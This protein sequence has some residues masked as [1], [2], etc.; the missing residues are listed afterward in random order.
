MLPSSRASSRAVAVIA[1]IS[2]ALVLATM[3]VSVSHVGRAQRRAPGSAPL[4]EAFDAAYADRFDAIAIAP[5]SLRVTSDADG[6]SRT[7]RVQLVRAR[8]LSEGCGRLTATLPGGRTWTISVNVL[9]ADASVAVPASAGA[10]ER[11]RVSVGDVVV[12]PLPEASVQSAQPTFEPPAACADRDPEMTLLASGG[13][14]HRACTLEGAPPRSW[15]LP[16]ALVDEVLRCE[17]SNAGVGQVRTLVHRFA[18][19]RRA[20][21]VRGDLRAIASGP[22]ELMAT[23][24]IDSERGRARDTTFAYVPR[25]RVVRVGDWVVDRRDD[26]DPVDEDLLSCVHERDSTCRIRPRAP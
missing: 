23:H 14:P 26:A 4:I 19:V 13:W 2:S 25:T 21:R 20:G 3:L 1:A 24:V 16:S 18:R 17:L 6:R 10:S 12:W 8:A 22:R 15:R 11:A 7:E 9:P 5:A